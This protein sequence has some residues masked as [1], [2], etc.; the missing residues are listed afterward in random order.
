LGH[1]VTF[2]RLLFKGTET[3]ISM[4]LSAIRGTYKYV[5]N[6][7]DRRKMMQDWADI[8]DGW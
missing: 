6:M 2:R 5:Q 1:I 3:N 7:N 8:V 4:V